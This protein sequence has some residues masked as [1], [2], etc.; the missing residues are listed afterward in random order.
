MEGLCGIARKFCR[1]SCTK[2]RQKSA[3][4]AVCLCA[5]LQGGIDMEAKFCFLTRL[6]LRLTMDH[7]PPLAKCTNWKNHFTFKA[8][9]SR[10]NSDSGFS[11]L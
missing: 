5:Y 4:V 9:S 1:G 8:S 2:V 7:L 6:L 11:T 10:T 3:A